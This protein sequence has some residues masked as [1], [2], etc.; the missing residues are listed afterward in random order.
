MIVTPYKW[1]FHKIESKSQDIT[2]YSGKQHVT[3]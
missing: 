3:T 1:L 2:L